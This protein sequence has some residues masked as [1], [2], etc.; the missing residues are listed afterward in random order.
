MFY[1]LVRDQS[2][3]MGKGW[4]ATK[5]L[6]GGASEVL[7]LQTGGWTEKVLA[8]LNRGHNSFEV[9]LT[10]EPEVLA[11]LKGGGAQQVSSL[12]GGLQKVLLCLEGMEQGG[13]VQKV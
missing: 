1:R 8:M 13:G 9:V 5:R 2:L 10:R 7:P 12:K 11:I 4:G 3:I 6:G